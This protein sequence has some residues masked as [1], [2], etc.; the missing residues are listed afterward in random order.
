MSNL[1]T[2][3]GGVQIPPVFRVKQ[4]FLNTV[5]QNVGN[6]LRLQLE[7]HAP[8]IHEGDRIAI[9]C[10]SRGLDRYP[11]IVRTVVNYIIQRGGQPFLLPAMGSHGGATS[12]GQR[13]LLARLGITEQS[14]GVPMLSSMD[15]VQ[16]G[17]A[18]NGQPIYINRYA[19]E[20]D[21][22]VLLNRIKPHTSF[23]GAYESGLVKMMAIGLANQRGAEAAHGLRYENMANNIAA[24]GR[25]ALQKLNIVCAVASIENGYGKVAE[26]HVLHP[27]EVLSREPA[28]LQRAFHLMPRIYL[29]EIDAL[30]VSE[31]GKDISGTGMDTNIVGRFHTIAAS[32][33]P[34]VSKLGLLD[35]SLRSDGNANGMGLADFVTKKLFQKID[36]APTY[37]NSLTSTEPNSTKLPMVLENDRLVVQACLKLC[38]QLDTYRSRLVF[39]RNTKNLNYV[40]MS[41]AAVGAICPGADV[42]VDEVETDVHFDTSGNL[43]LFDLPS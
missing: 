43:R 15:T 13:E 25:A 24:I 3:L 32:G 1:N 17:T 34:R 12:Q 35:L 40:Y 27:N 20:A 41:G 28:L 23:R 29:D 6:T 2:M 37:M 18:E 14:M 5:V 4:R 7:Q 21:G 9:T 11:D 42:E 8:P 26:L 22:I 30:V 36:F 39:I 19:A 16:V 31:I 33:G 38:G 10:G